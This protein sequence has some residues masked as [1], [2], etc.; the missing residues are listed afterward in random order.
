MKSIIYTLIAC[1]AAGAAFSAHADKICPEGAGGR[2]V[3][4]SMDGTAE[5][6]PEQIEKKLQE[7][8]QIKA[9]TKRNIAYKID[10]D[11]IMKPLTE[12]DVAGSVT[13][14][15][16]AAQPRI[17]VKLRNGKSSTSAAGLKSAKERAAALNKKSKIT[18]APIIA[19]PAPK[20]K[21]QLTRKQILQNEIRNEQAAL[22][23]A[24]A[25]LNVAKKKGDQ[26]KISRLN[27]AVRDREANIRAIQGEI[28]R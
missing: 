12:A 1:L 27:Q 25:Q 18:P 21:P 22:A 28:K 24:K 15:A 26:A 3:T 16:P 13:N 17:D 20:P 6:T 11:V 7:T 9:E 4:E 23:R 8:E 14:S 2:C 10:D 19:A 5:F